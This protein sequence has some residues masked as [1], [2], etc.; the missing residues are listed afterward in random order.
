MIAALHAGAD[1]AAVRELAGGMRDS[2]CHDGT[3]PGWSDELEGMLREGEGDPSG[4]LEA[5]DR[6]LA[7]PLSRPAPHLAACH[8]G[9]ARVLVSLGRSQEAVVRAQEADALLCRWPGPQQTEARRLLGR[10][11]GRGR[12]SAQA[13]PGGNVAVGAASLLTP[14]EREVAALLAE[15]LTNAEVAQ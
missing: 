13:A 10:L 11:G 4:A 2:V 5:Y 15:G 7:H 12:A 8:L 9:A 1:A 3:D 6:A 14:R